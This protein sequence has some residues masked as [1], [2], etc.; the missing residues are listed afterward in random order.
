M[1]AIDLLESQHR[2]VEDLFAELAQAED[3]ELKAAAFDELADKLAI[4]SSLE[5]HQ[6]YPAVKAKQTEVVLLESLQ[7]HVT[8]ERLLADLLE[9]D[10]EDDRF[11]AQMHALRRA[12]ER[13]VMEEEGELFPEVRRLFTESRLQEI[14]QAMT[15]E[16]DELMGQGAPRPA[17]GHSANI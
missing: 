7:E 11:D 2:E 9:T 13:H 17:M 14:G 15:A 8:I 16:E 3:V 6:F 12:V 4:H 5:E 1:N 10:V